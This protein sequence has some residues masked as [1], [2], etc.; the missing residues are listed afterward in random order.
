MS[1]PSQFEVAGEIPFPELEE[2]LRG[3]TLLNQPDVHPYEDAS[4]SIERFKWD[5]VLPTSKY[6]LSCQ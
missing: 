2:R 4:I 1:T 3:I 6:V 5:D